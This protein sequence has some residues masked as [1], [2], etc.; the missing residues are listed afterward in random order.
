MSDGGEKFTI[1][2]KQ[3]GDR[4]VSKPS[5]IAEDSVKHRLTVRRRAGDG[6]KNLARRGLLLYG[7]RKLAPQRLNRIYRFGRLI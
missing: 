3:C 5:G 2:K 6:A 4:R 1:V 7:V